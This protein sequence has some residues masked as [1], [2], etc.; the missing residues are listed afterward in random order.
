MYES[1][2]KI[3]GLPYAR[4]IS[5]I[6]EQSLVVMIGERVVQ[7]NK[8]NNLIGEDIIKKVGIICDGTK[9]VY[10]HENQ[11][12]SSY[13]CPSSSS[14]PHPGQLRRGGLISVY[15]VLFCLVLSTMSFTFYL[16]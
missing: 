15:V 7:M 14:L 9:Y 8:F 3:G 6:L 10:K 4:E 5:K 16:D 1:R 11:P 2:L 13:T 12:S